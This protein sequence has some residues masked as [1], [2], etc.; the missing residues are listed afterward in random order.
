MEKYMKKEKMLTL[1]LI[2][3]GL[4]Y[5]FNVPEQAFLDLIKLAPQILECIGLDKFTIQ[6]SKILEVLKAKSQYMNEVSWDSAEKETQVFLCMCLI[7]AVLGGLLHD[8]PL[9]ICSNNALELM[10][11]LGGINVTDQVESGSLPF[12]SFIESD[13]FK[14]RCSQ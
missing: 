9:M 12:L 7:L 10:E 11:E 6:Y 5:R 2:G 14:Q 13:M 3:H 1:D 4:D 8:I